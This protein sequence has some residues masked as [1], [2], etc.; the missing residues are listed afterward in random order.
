MKSVFHNRKKR[1]TEEIIASI[2]DA[3][4]HDVTKTRIMYVSY[5][6]FGQL[7][8]YISYVLETRLMNLDSTSNKYRTT[9]KG[10]E[11]L[12]RFEEVH[13]IENNIIEKRRS[14]SAILESRDGQRY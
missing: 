8:R 2:L 3:A 14:L 7:Q 5:L 9:T 10:L 11:F 13:S 12:S 1:N 4:R 6:S